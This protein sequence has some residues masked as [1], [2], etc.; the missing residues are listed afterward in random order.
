MEI[1]MANRNE[2]TENR[3][4]TFIKEAIN[5]CEYSANQRR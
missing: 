1:D 3:I 4:N 2:K 5:H